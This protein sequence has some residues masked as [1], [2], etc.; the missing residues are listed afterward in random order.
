MLLTATTATMVLLVLD[1]SALGVMLPT[2]TDDLHL[3]ASQSSWL[4]SVYLLALAVFAPLGGRLADAAGAATMFRIGMTGFVAASVVIAAFPSFPAVM[5]G[6]AIAGV[7]GAMLMPATLTLLMR[8]IAQ[9]RRAAAM[10]SYTGVGQGF[11]LIGPLLGGLCAQYLGWQWAFL[12]NV[13]VGVTALVL[14]HL[15]HPADVRGERQPFDFVGVILVVIGMTAVVTAL[16]QGPDWGWGSAAVWSSACIGA[17]TLACYFVKYRRTS[18]PVIDLDLLKHSTFAAGTLVLA[19]LGFAMTVATVYGAV[20][21]QE[22]LALT[23]AQ[24]GVA[25]IPLVVPLLIA[26]RMVGARYEWYGLRRVVVGGCSAL[27][28]GSAISAVGFTASAP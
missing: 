28:V 18:S 19:A 2:M 10:A 1:S 16:L 14:V 8:E 25:L 11:A 12:I 13:P 15:A 23:P 22:A 7:A 26:T 20:A 4:V 21:L 17:L 9:R 5:A 6:R 3:T 27:A 24:A